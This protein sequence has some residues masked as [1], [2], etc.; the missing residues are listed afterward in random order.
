MPGQV[1]AFI[2][3]R[4]D[5]PSTWQAIGFAVGLTGS[6]YGANIDWGQGAA[7]G[8][9]ISATIKA[10]TPDDFTGVVSRAWARVKAEL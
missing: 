10:F 2:L 9:V 7:L 5:E 8:G 3:D 6:H 1:G 4:L